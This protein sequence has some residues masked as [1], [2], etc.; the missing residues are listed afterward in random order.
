MNRP[1]RSVLFA[2]T[3]IAIG[4][5]IAWYGDPGRAGGGLGGS[6]AGGGLGGPGAGGDGRG[7]PAA[8]TDDDT[9]RILRAFAERRS[10]EWVTATGEVTRLLPDDNEGSRHQRFIVRLDPGHTLL[11]S[12]NIDLAPRIDA[13]RTGDRVTFRGEYEWNDRGGVVHWTHHDPQ[14]RHDGGWILH[15]GNEYR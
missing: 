5:A 11:I 14:G 9:G 12:H 2:L 4:A 3:A 7:G 15:D 1:L 10:D 13:L 6:G 8:T